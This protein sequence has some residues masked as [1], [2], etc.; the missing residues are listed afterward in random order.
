MNRLNLLSHL[1]AHS[2]RWRR[3]TVWSAL[4]GTSAA[5]TAVAQHSPTTAPQVPP[6]AQQPEQVFA[7][8]AA[9]DAFVMKQ[10]PSGSVAD[11]GSYS[12]D[13]GIGGTGALA[14]MGHIAGE[15]VGRT[16][17]IT[18]FEV[19]PYAFVDNTMWYTDGRFY[20]TNNGHIGGTGGVGVRQFLP[21]Y[22]SIIG[23]GAFYD[24]DDTRAKMFTQAGLSVEYL[25]E[26]L[27]VRTNLY[28]NTGRTSADLGTSF[29]RGSEHFVDDNIAFN[30]RT[31][32]AAAT[33]GLDLTLTVPV[34]GQV[35]QAINMEASAGGY[36]YV[37]NDFNL[38]DATG[39]RLRLDADFM[40]QTLH[41][42]LDFTS[43]KVFNNNLVFGADLNYYHDVQRRPRMG[44][45]QFNRMSEWVRRNYNVVAIDQ[46]IVN[47]DELA[48]NPITGTPY[49]VLHVRNIVPNDPDFPNYPAPAGN[50]SVDTPYQFID[51]AQDDPKD[52]DIIFV[53]SG[54][55]F[56]DMPV[57][58]EAN[59]Q[60][61]G[62]GVDHP[63]KVAN[64]I[65]NNGT[66]LLP[67]ATVPP[68]PPI[69]PV[70]QNT[71]GTAVTLAD[72]SVF[73]GFD[74]VN[75]TG[76]AILGDGINGSEI[77]DVS[78]EGTNGATSHGL[79]LV[80]TT[81]T[82]RVEQ[83]ITDGV[84][85]TDLFIDG[86]S[87]NVNWFGGLLENTAGRAVVVQNQTGGI[88]NLAGDNATNP[89]LGF[90]GLTI[91]DNGGEG[92]LIQDTNAAVV[93]GR[94]A[95][96]PTSSP[97]V[98]LQNSTTTGLSILNLGQ[99]GSVSILRG[100]EIDDA[101]DIP[102]LIQN[103]QG[104]F[105]LADDAGLANDLVILG[106]GVNTAI[107]LN[108]I[109][110]LSQI[111]FEGDTVIGA[112]PALINDDPAINFHN[113]STG[114]V[115]FNGDLSIGQV[116]RAGESDAGESVVIN[117]GDANGVQ[118]NG[119]G[120]TFEAN[121]DVTIVGS[122]GGPDIRIGGSVDNTD[123][124]NPIIIADPTN[125]TFGR[126]TTPATVTIN[127]V[128]G[129]SL[130]V[131]GSSGTIRFNS[132]LIIGDS[133]GRQI[134]VQ[135]N[136]GPVTFGTVDIGTNVIAGDSV[137][138]VSRN[139]GNVSFGSLSIENVGGISFF[140]RE[141]IDLAINGGVIDSFGGQAIDIEN[142]AFGDPGFIFG[143]KSLNVTF[144]SVT[145]D[146]FGPALFGI[147]VVDNSAVGDDTGNIISNPDSSF[148]ILGSGT[149]GSGGLISS[150]VA[151]GDG[152]LPRG[153]IFQNID[154]VELNSQDYDLNEGL[155]ILSL[156]TVNFTLN[157]SRL[158]QNGTGN[159][160]LGRHQILL[161]VDQDIEDVDTYNYTISNNLMSDATNNALL[162]SDAL[163]QIDSTNLS[164]GATLNLDIIDNQ[165]TAA[166]LPGFFSNRDA[167]AGAAIRV[168]WNGALNAAVERNGFELAAGADNQI[169]LDIVQDGTAFVNNVSFNQNTLLATGTGDDGLTGVRMDFDGRTNLE[170]LDNAVINQQT[171]AVTPGFLFSGTNAT[172]FDLRLR[173]VGNQVVFDDNFLRFNN[174]GGTGLLFSIINSSDV[175][176]GDDTGTFTDFGNR[177][178]LT[179]TDATFERGIIFQTTFGTVN[180][181]GTQNNEIVPIPI[182]PGFGGFVPF[183]P[184]ASSTGSII[185]NGVRQP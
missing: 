28:T 32:R 73:A 76:T 147:R 167:T 135:N 83:L 92:I 156:N 124:D 129:D 3:V 144:D 140:A 94:S 125:V 182:F 132:A 10:P 66:I 56:T 127:P 18:H 29:I 145:A 80:D 30:T 108:N 104:D 141:N 115:R 85:G 107:E 54:S 114:V 87:S 109:G 67:T 81:G 31:R 177:I 133:I 22:N 88:I 148:R 43:D 119:A 42:F 84:E 164:N 112:V 69:L 63:I 19:M 49:I 33:D 59:Q 161:R 131:E 126:T 50:G 150:G 117:I 9:S 20:T 60:L 169:G 12:R 46:T 122:F 52:A 175:A 4:L 44:H 157:N 51:Q 1:F 180:L 77:R 179:D 75:T 160:P 134:T 176:I 15:T 128:L 185:I 26:F 27:D 171:G 86:G 146:G 79:H 95:D 181:S 118:I 138:N 45:N 116:A 17:S 158:T 14:R 7:Q 8:A 38:D 173:A 24:A 163:L 106:R 25:S 155:A 110:Q 53:H 178:E 139:T 65:A 136:T 98:L 21:N 123:P 111:V 99:A 137:V 174:V 58:L 154:T 153:A 102:L 184:P 16:Q 41:T 74:I 105:L 168:D 72:N 62:E 68:N 183:Q 97:G 162:T 103:S 71:L 13:I 37:A 2:A 93:F 113:G 82:I 70:L 61:L 166:L 90:G 130:V 165:D 34:P 152:F 78:I 5:A 121:G 89:A 35:F 149:R 159:D 142:F 100:L 170:M 151:L 57:V 55:V 143:D 120:A 91:T 36:H 96:T 23:V 39:Y 11:R 40:S 6:G 172:G 101:A 64:P 47:P 48:I